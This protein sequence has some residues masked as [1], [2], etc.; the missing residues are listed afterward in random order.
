V[1]SSGPLKGYR[2]VIKSI[3]KERIEVRVPQKSQ[4]EW[5]NRSNLASSANR[6]RMEM[7]KTPN[8]MAMST[9]QVAG[10]SPGY[11]YN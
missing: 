5:I 2:G 1:I 10:M 6:D 3:N 11:H 4:T 7:G 8:R 9:H